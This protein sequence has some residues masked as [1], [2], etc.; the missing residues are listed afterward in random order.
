MI[1][2]PKLTGYF[3]DYFT[4]FYLM[5]LFQLFNVLLGPFHKKRE[6]FRQAARP[7]YKDLASK[8]SYVY[9]ACAQ[10]LQKRH[11]GTAK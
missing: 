8:T 2:L 1:Y 6:S 11:T 7:F 9:C 5:I 3:G 10:D 4:L